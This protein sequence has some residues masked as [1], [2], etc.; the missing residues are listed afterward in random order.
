MKVKL[1]MPGWAPYTFWGQMPFKFPSLSL[2]TLAAYTPD[3]IDISI[4]DENV[5]SIDFNDPVDLVG[6]TV[7]TPLAYRAYGIADRFRKMGTTVVLGGF[8]PTWMTDEA[9]QHADTVVVGEGEELWPQVL[10]DFRQG[11]LAKIYRSDTPVDLLRV[12]RPRRSLLEGKKYLFTN[13][14]QVT[15]GCPYACEFCSVTAFFGK[16][17][18]TRAIDSVIEEMAEMV[19]K[20]I[21]VFIVD[22][23]IIYD[24]HYAAALFS[25]MT[26]LKIKWLSHASL[27]FASDRKLMN[28]AAKSGCLGMFVGIESLHADNIAMMGKKTNRNTSFAES[29]KVFHDNGIG[30]LASFVLGYDYDDRNTIDRLLDFCHAEKVDSAIFPVL[31]P[32]PGTALRERLS[33]QNRI[34]SSDWSRYD[35]EHVNFQPRLMSAAELQEGFERINEGFWSFNSMLRRL[36]KLQRSN[37]VFVPMNIGFRSAWKKSRKTPEQKGAL[38][39]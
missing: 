19:Q 34:L 38:C 29:I 31:T 3:D 10:N 14:I 9:L 6:I 20:N 30:V 35:M 32:F 4:T 13:M 37:Q 15:R 27:D 26:H 11:R 16:R 8:H 23:N 25:E 21:F 18:R 7:M 28:L 2:V 39:L 33:C 12:K 22:D 17:F 5:E 36:C 1:I 24:K